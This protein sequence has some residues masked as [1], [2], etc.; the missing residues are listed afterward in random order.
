[1]TEELDMEAVPERVSESRQ[2]AKED[3]II[4]INDVESIQVLTDSLINNFLAGL[5]QEI[6]GE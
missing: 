1:M 4:E 5:Q 6:A 2:P 3:I